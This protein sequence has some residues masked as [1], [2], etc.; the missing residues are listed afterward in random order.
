MLNRVKIVDE[1]ALTFRYGQQMPDP[2]DGLSLF[3]PC[4]TD[5]PGHPLSLSF[6][7]VGTRNGIDLFLRWSRAMMKPATEAPNDRYRLWPPFPGFGAAFECDWVTR[8]I[9][10]EGIASNILSDVAHRHDPYERVFSVVSLYLDA[11]ES[12]GKLDSPPRVMVCVVPDLV[13]STCR[14][15]SRVAA[16]TGKNVKKKERD[17]RKSGQGDLFSQ[18]STAISPG[19]ATTPRRSRR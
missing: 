14:I 2:R 13:Y 6:G 19:S 15:Q 16:T 10:E 3:G 12:L 5:E 9:V 8:P 7:V 11:F 1:P 4:D 17:L 18:Y